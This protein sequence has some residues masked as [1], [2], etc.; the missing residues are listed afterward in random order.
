MKK[1]IKLLAIAASGALMTTWAYLM[2]TAD[3]AQNDTLCEENDI[4]EAEENEEADEE[5][6]A[7][8]N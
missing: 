1:I 4:S 5:L 7:D 3:A 8:T 2:G 6:A